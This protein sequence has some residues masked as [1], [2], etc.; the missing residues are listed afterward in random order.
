MF[1]RLSCLNHISNDV[2]L[3]VASWYQNYFLQGSRVKAK[4][5]FCLNAFSVRCFVFKRQALGHSL[6]NAPRIPEVSYITAVYKWS[7][8]SQLVSRLKSQ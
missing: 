2:I 5:Y 7:E 1:F 4:V 8:L 6:M 3:R